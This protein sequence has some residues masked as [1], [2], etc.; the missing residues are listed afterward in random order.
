[1]GCLIL[2]MIAAIVAAIQF[3]SDGLLKMTFAGLIVFACSLAAT[4]L[5]AHYTKAG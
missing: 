5:T 2:S 3:Q 1:M 4:L